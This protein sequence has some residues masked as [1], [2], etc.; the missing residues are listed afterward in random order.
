MIVPHTEES[1]FSLRIPLFVVQVT[2]AILVMSLVGVSVLG[3]A[4]LKAAAEA[5]EANM[6]RQINRAQ[7][8]EI[9]A[10]AIE[11]EKMMEQIQTIDELVELV[12]DKLDLDPGDLNNGVQNQAFNGP[13]LY[14][15][16]GVAEVYEYDR[17]Y[18]SRSSSADGV[19]GRA[20]E[21]IILLQNI[22]PERTETL[23]SVGEFV[24]QADAKPSI[25]PCRGRISSGFGGR[26]IPYSGGYQFHNGV[27]I[28][29]AHGSKVWATAGGKV[30]FTGYRG[31]SLKGPTA[32]VSLC[33]SSC[34]RK[35]RLMFWA[36]I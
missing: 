32:L 7:Q 14:V 4:Y 35:P 11:T 1:T 34:E 33:H 6:L 9:N 25:W 19:L 26:R 17:F 8:E 27:D 24:D 36:S 10:L 12:T 18:G 20:S 21:N 22:I 30:I 5:S 15:A 13:N 2:V 31:D 16:N 28:I 3:Y 23:D 29:G